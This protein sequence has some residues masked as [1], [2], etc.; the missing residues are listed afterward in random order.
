M[1]KQ[2]IALLLVLGGLVASSASHAGVYTFSFSG[3]SDSGSGTF[4]VTPDSALTGITG[5]IDAEPI[6]GLSSYGPSDNII[7]YGAPHID[8]NGFAFT[9]AGDAFNI[10]YNNIPNDG[11]PIGIYLLQ[12]SIDPDPDTSPS[13]G[14]PITFTTSV[15]V[16][17]PAT[18]AMMIVGLGLAG[19]GL[20]RGV[21][22]AARV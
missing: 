3:A 19:A 18:W 16:P 13:F 20:R 4:T 17:E 21:R 1:N 11:A 10:Y 5:S 14:E 6:T 2:K 15:P 12:Q 22:W 7:T 9:I 8:Y